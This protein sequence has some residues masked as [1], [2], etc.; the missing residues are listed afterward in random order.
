[1]WEGRGALKS[2]QGA[3]VT[4]APSAIPLAD[5][6][7]VP[8]ALDRGGMNA[9]RDAFVA[10]TRRAAR[11]GFD[12]IE[13]HSTH[14]YLLSEFLSPLANKRTDEFGG[15]LQNRMRFPLEVIRAVRDAWPRD[16]VLGAK[17]SGTDFAQ[18]GWTPEEAVIYARELKTLGYDYVT[19][20]GGGVVL[21]A[22]VPVAPG[23]QV[24]YAE[25]VRREIGITTGS[26]GLITD[27]HQAED[28]IATGKAD[29]VSLA[30]AMLFDPRWPWHAAVA[31]GA[32]LKYPPQYERC[33]PK[34]WPGAAQRKQ[35]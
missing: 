2:G 10:S 12:F 9:V 17:I 23:Y 32:D 14:G 21:D 28:I 25:R 1:P 31:L 11:I 16:K 34:A 8:A 27:P 26:V 29:F 19:V 18:G 24:P 6:W 3:W 7:P 15:S 35:L 33:H 5:G 13:V 30:R 22:K 20:S 4:V